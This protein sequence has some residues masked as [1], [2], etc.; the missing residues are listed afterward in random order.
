MVS[1]LLR[2]LLF[3]ILQPGVVG[4]LIPYLILRAEGRDLWPERFAVTHILGLTM[5]A[6]GFGVLLTCVVRFATEGKG[7]ISPLDPTREVV[8]G[9]LYRYTRNPMYLGG[10]VGVLGEAV[11]WWSPW[12]LVYSAVVFASFN[13]FV[14]LHEEPRMRRDFGDDY[15]R[16][17]QRVR[18][19][20]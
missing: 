11:F 4:G 15:Q 1:L 2:N 18:R 5:M 12:L 7:T 17:S 20:F 19:W 14:I 6:A 13:L 3:T 9:G 10:V 8:G 16:Y